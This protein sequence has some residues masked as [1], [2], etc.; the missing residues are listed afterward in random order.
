MIKELYEHQAQTHIRS[1]NRKVLNLATLLFC[2]L[3]ISACSTGSWR[4]ASRESANIAPDP[5]T[6]PEA[7]IHVYAADAWGWR[8]LF[9]VHTWIAVKPKAADKYTVLEV[10][11]WREKRGLPVL[12]VEQDIPD[13]FWYG[14]K[15][16]LILEKRGGDTDQ[17]INKILH[18]SKRYP[19]ENTY[20][21]FPG[22]NSNTFPAWIA[23]NVPELGLDLPFRAIG[24]GWA[25]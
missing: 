13:R 2:V 5:S 24:S 11:G 6:T 14:S 4:D 9:A 7:V 18:A 3:F 25:E 15:P 19:W 17:V 22:P 23:M 12:R 1:A 8:G 16:E 10:I 21:V 20:Q